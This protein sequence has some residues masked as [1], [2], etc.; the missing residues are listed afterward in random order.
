MSELLDNRKTKVKCPKCKSTNLYLVEEGTWGTSHYQENGVIQ[1]DS[2]NNE[3]GDYYKLTGECV[4]C[5]HKWT[6]KN[7]SNVLSVIIQD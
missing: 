4:E 3:P 1:P 5:N 2:H 6:I 7:A